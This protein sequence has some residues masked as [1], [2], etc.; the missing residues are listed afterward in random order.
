MTDLLQDLHKGMPEIL[1]FTLNTMNNSKPI[2]LTLKRKKTVKENSFVFIVR[3]DKNGNSILV[4]ENVLSTLVGTTRFWNNLQQ[5]RS[6]SEH[7][8]DK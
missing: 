1:K 8:K 6:K 7:W 3:K 4:K 5:V 2:K